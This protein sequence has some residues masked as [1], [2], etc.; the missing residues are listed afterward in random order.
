MINME[1]VKTGIEE[2]DSKLDG[3]YPRGRSLLVTGTTGS[4]KTILGIHFIYRSCL[5]GKKCRIIATEE[6][7][8]DLLLQ[9]ESIGMPLTEFIKNGTLAIDK[10]YEERTWHA[11]EVLVMGI[12]KLD[13]LQSN[14]I[15]LYERIPENTEILLID[16]IGVFTLN[17]SPNEFRSQFDSLIYNLL[18]RNITSMVV[19]D[20]ASDERLGGVA[21][22]SVYGIIRTSIKDNPYT[23]ARER[24]LELIKV[25]NTTIPLNPFRFEI[26]SKG[27]E[28]VKKEK[29]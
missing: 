27:I 14:I 12:E 6:I 4:G 29:K 2:L 17:M 23:G 15:G 5:E 11:Q 1:R 13:E 10:V 18:K 26:T 28:F 16:N 19:L 20:T 24:L 8:E 25:R 21:S 22:Y 7:P 9:A 3:G